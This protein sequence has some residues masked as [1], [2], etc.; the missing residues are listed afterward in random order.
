[1]CLNECVFKL[2]LFLKHRNYSYN[3][4]FFFKYE[5]YIFHKRN[6]IPFLQNHEMILRPHLPQFCNSIL[7]L[8]FSYSYQWEV[9]V[10]TAWCFCSVT[11]VWS[12]GRTHKHEAGNDPKHL[13]HF[14]NAF[15]LQ[16]VLLS[17]PFRTWFAGKYFSHLLP[18]ISCGASGDGGCQASSITLPSSDRL[19][20]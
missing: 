6:V 2:L 13:S 1:M 8:Q 17:S 9:T 15:A 20:V 10:Y 16:M 11:M 18:G 5:W 4:W 14:M 7:Q 12:E 19:C 3:F